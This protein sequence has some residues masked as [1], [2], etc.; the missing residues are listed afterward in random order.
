MAYFRVT[1]LEMPFE[2]EAIYRAL[3]PSSKKKAEMALTI[4]APLLILL[5]ANCNGNHNED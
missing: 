1:A 5:Q 4:P 3:A 2:L